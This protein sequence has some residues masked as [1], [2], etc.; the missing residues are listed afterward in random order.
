MKMTVKFC[1]FVLVLFLSVFSS[2]C[3][4]APA[5]PE[6]NQEFIYEAK[7]QNGIFPNSS[8]V[9]TADAGLSSVGTDISYNTCT[10]MY[11]GRSAATRYRSVV[12]FDLSSLPAGAEV[13][14]AELKLSI[15]GATSR[16]VTVTAYDI[17][18]LWESVTAGCGVSAGNSYDP[19]WNGPWSTA[20]GDLSS[21]VSN[22]A[23]I[24]QNS[25]TRYLTLNLDTALV[26]RWIRNGTSLNQAESNNG[27]LLKG[28]DET[29]TDAYAYFITSENTDS[30]QLAPLLIVYYKNGL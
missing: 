16:G 15:Q 29:S 1:L 22:S 3:S 2:S 26:Q 7:F 14:K 11:V 10:E 17:S 8:Y 19:R 28:T 24:S 13:V 18:N 5:A 25:V 21:P 9:F 30:P 23:Y 6:Y 12:K 4:Q 20:G 27:V